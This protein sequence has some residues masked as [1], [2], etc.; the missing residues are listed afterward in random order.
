MT[1]NRPRILYPQW[2]FR[3]AWLG[4]GCTIAVLF[5]TGIL[6]AVLA[7]P[8]GFRGVQHDAQA[9]QLSWDTPPADLGYLLY[10]SVD[11]RSPEFHQE[12]EIPIR[13]QS[14]IIWDAPRGNR[15]SYLFYLVAVDAKGMKSS[16]SPTIRVTLNPRPSV[17]YSAGNP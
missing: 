10:A 9:V 4:V 8:T 15:K 2:R 12:N 5:R 11:Q 7:A 13:N 16:P 17:G 3:R 14:F 1:V 6:Q